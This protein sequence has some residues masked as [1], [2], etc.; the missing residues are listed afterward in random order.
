MDL[1]GDWLTVLKDATKAGWL[2]MK[3]DDLVMACSSR[4]HAL[5][6]RHRIR[7]HHHRLPGIHRRRHHLDHRRLQIHVPRHWP[8][9]RRE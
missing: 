2:M 9:R 6:R 5:L 3:E 8:H 4:V 7:R 1:K